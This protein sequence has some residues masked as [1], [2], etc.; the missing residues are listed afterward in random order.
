MAKKFTLDGLFKTRERGKKC[1]KGII[2]SF[3]LVWFVKN[4]KKKNSVTIKKTTSQL[5]F[6]ENVKKKRKVNIYIY[7]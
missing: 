4:W 3:L 1:E 5:F 6:H 2:F 7:I